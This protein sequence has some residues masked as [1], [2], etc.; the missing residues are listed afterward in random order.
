MGYLDE[1]STLVKD[2]ASAKNAIG[3]IPRNKSITRGALDGTIQFPCLVSDAIPIDMASTIA[4]TLERVYASFTQ[5][6]LSLNNTID[7]S[8]DK[9]PNMFLKKFH[10]NIKVES[11]A[12]DV[13]NEYC[14]ESDED[15]T[16]LMERIYDGSTKAY[17]NE[18]ENRMILFNFS[19][20]LSPEV[21]ES[22]KQ[23]L[24]ESL[25]AID[26]APFPNI[27]NSPFYE[28]DN[29]FDLGVGKSSSSEKEKFI[30]SAQ[31]A[32]QKAAY[33]T[34]KA[35]LTSQLTR[36]NDTYKYQVGGNLTPPSLLK[37][38]DVKKQNDLQPYLMQ[39]RLMAVNDKNE[40]VQFM[41]FIV[42][43]KVV[44]HLIKSDEV[45]SNLQNALQNSGKLFNFIRWTTGEK[46]LF[47]DLLFHINDTKLDVANKTKGSSP[48]W[49]TLKRMKNTSKAQ[50][51]FFA[52]N[53]LVPN[54]TIVISSY[55][56]DIIRN[57]YGT[58]LR[59]AKF[60]IK[61]MSSLFLM[62]FII[63]DE[64][65]RTI[66]VLYDGETSYQTYALETLEREISL[67]SNKIGKELTRMISR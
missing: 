35:I 2:M 43:V 8:V 11:T 40:F 14:M 28:A 1:L 47:K 54:S 48:W 64:G 39:V 42:G 60:A 65:T 4:K 19:E 18:K 31:L 55:E 58:D 3:N 7:I 34:D 32:K 44:L 36:A 62:N 33:D 17:V 67:N 6:Y 53:Q 10:H 16:K 12:E 30:N 41:D 15:Y 50:G 38:N 22:H 26:F 25:S 59:N 63:V 57:K 24:E 51:A 13:Y 20:K 27:G 29:E 23:E 45:I 5:S 37:D 61:L 49:M 9:N 21:F 66:E 56:A 46:S 52:R